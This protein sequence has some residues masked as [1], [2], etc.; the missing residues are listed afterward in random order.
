M[1]AWYSFS[2]ARDPAAPSRRECHT[3]CTSGAKLFLF[4]G[5]DDAGRFRDVH[6]LD[7]AT[8]RWERNTPANDGTS[9]G[10]RSAHTAVMDAAGRWM[11]VYGGWD[12]TDEL[13]DVARFDTGARLFAPLAPDPRAPAAA[14]PALSPPLPLTPQT[15]TAPPP[16]PP[17]TP[18][19][20][21][22]ACGSAWPPRARPPRPA[23]STWR[24][25]WAAACTCLAAT[26][27]RCGATT[28][29]R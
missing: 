5:N 25:A 3:I 27:A 26:T 9:P 20:Q 19:P 15:H 24:R 1:A 29:W 14:H 2:T 22:P 12:G 7:T 21:W 10:N 18:T 4:G 8:M 23:T 11:Y 16:R 28:W 17:T 13:G 6:V